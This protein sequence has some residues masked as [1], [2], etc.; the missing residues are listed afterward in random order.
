LLSSARTGRVSGDVEAEQR[1]CH[2][3]MA[4]SK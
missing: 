1:L 4:L 2:V 3:A